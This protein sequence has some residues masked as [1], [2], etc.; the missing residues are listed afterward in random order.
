MKT[1]LSLCLGAAVA[2]LFTACASSP[3][4]APTASTGANRPVRLQLT[5][6]I[7]SSMNRVAEEDV[8]EAFAYHV[9]AALHDQGVRGSIHYIV[10]GD[11]VAPG[12]PVL[13]I[14][15]REWRVDPL[16][17]VDCTFSALLRT[18]AGQRDLGLFTGNSMMRWDRPDWYERQQDFEDAARDAL[19][20]LARRMRD[21]GLLADVP[22]RSANR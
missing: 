22:M 4:R 1:I 11:P 15:L 14:T 20:N 18:P 8:A 19:N 13:A 12:T 7:P 3:M 5:V 17:N 2:A 9:S 16:G 10:Q 6:D 21:T